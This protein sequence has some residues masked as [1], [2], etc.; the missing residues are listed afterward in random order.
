M[1][2]IQFAAMNR[3]TVIWTMLIWLS[4]KL[5]LYFLR[6]ILPQ[7]LLLFNSWVVLLNIHV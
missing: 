1:S 3:G 4:E 6:R 7:S 2:G 5:S